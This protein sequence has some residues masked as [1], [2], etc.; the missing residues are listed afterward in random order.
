MF[1]FAWN[2]S[3]RFDVWTL[4]MKFSQ[5]EKNNKLYQR[6]E[7]TNICQLIRI[8][9]YN[10]YNMQNGFRERIAFK[11]IFSYQFHW[12]GNLMLIYTII[13]YKSLHLQ[14]FLHVKMKG[15]LLHVWSVRPITSN[16]IVGEIVFLLHG[17]Y[18]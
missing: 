5:C 13:Q 8:H 10:L 15:H 3:L 11:C 6:S 9:V 1:C 18:M 4:L 14:H 17:N 16:L 2:Q 12:Y 7:I